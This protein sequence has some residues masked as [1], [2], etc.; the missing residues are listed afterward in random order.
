MKEIVGA[1]PLNRN[2]I[3]GTKKTAGWVT[4]LGFEVGRAHN[5]SL[6]G[7]V[8]PKSFRINSSTR[9]HLGSVRLWIAAD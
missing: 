3:L 2:L 9:A 7:E 4:R 1:P 6:L 5:Y 8:W